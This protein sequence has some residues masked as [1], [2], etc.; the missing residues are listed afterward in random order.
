MNRRQYL[1]LSAALIYQASGRFGWAQA[2]C[3]EF[4]N[5]V[6]TN[7]YDNRDP[8]TSV[9]TSGPLSTSPT[10][11]NTWNDPRLREWDADIR[12]WENVRSETAAKLSDLIA[13]INNASPGD[14][15]LADK[16]SQLIKNLAGRYI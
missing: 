2:I 3:A 14:K 11:W 4:S 1:V 8:S 15:P 13:Q 10:P 5:G 16:L 9:G 12:R 7:C 6:V